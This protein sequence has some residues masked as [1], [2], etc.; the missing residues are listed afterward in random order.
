[1]EIPI[2]IKDPEEMIEVNDLKEEDKNKNI[3]K[4]EKNEFI[5]FQNIKPS[6]LILIKNFIK[7]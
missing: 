6:Y 5:N 4:E 2:Q 3:V 7:N 1:M